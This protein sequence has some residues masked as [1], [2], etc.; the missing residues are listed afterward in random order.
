MSC[1]IEV[2]L[3]NPT[4]L[5]SESP[6][7]TE[8]GRMGAVGRSEARGANAAGGAYAKRPFHFVRT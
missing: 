7:G 5:G 2:Y 4:W 1:L 8:I 3:L 6:I